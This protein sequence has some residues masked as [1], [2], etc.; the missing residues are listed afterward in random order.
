MK[1]LAV[2]KARVKTQNRS[3]K[4]TRAKIFNLKIER[5][6]LNDLIQ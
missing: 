3:L 1:V 5:R 6:T 4:R 2:L